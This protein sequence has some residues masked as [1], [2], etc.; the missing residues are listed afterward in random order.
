MDMFANFGIALF[1]FLVLLTPLVFVHELGHFLIARWNGVRVDVFSIGFGPELFGW[2]DKTGTRWKV[3]AVPLGGYIKMF[4]EHA[5][6]GA[7][8]EEEPREMTEEEKKVSFDQKRLSQRAWIVFAGPA[9]NYIFA[10]IIMAS[11]FMFLGQR[12]TPPE[13]GTVAEGSSAAVAGLRPGDVVLSIDG[14]GVSRFEDILMKVG[15]R[16]GETLA[17]E[18]ER[19]GSVMSIPVTT[20]VVEAKQIDNTVQKVGDLGIRYPMPAL[21]RDVVGGS[22]A[23]A[24]GLQ[25][26]DVIV[27]VDAA[28]IEHFADLQKI[29]ADSPEK[30]LTLVVLRDGRRVNLAATPEKQQVTRA[31]GEVVEYGMLGVRVDAVTKVIKLGPVDAVGG[32]VKWVYDLTSGSLM[33]I[34]QMVM[35]KRDSSQ[36]GGPIMIAQVSSEAASLGLGWFLQ[37]MAMISVSLGLINLFPVPVLDGGHLMFYGIE[38]VRGRPLGERAQEY[39]F[40]IGLALVL[41]LMIFVTV[42]DLLHRVL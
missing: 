8:E 39:S 23:D 34:G 16:P 17:L 14:A 41:S 22:A 11:S 10:V 4:G 13:I 37:F 3:C 15:M 9:A 32:A 30:A 36:M 5:L 19:D 1:W 42:N 20:D 33:A 2:N 21:V 18:I 6:E 31:D 25:S 27:E 29:V 12:F 24:A 28:T 38:A 7:G 26:G 40:R 35:G